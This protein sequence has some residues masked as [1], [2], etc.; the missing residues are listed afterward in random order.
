[1]SVSQVNTIDMASL[2]TNAYELGDMIN[3]SADV[4]NY[5]FWKR[6]VEGNEAIQAAIRQFVKKKELFEEC[7]RFGHFHPDYHAAKD[8]M[9]QAEKEL[10][11]Y[12]EVRRFKEAER[13]LDEMLY[14]I[15]ATIA[16]SVS[17]TIKVPSNDPNPKRGGCNCGGGGGCAGSCG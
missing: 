12:E 13:L 14:N 9:E 10:E 6:R 3:N 11:S 8:S 2:L 4:A 15:S 1:M 17:E 7:Q 16:Y 5:L